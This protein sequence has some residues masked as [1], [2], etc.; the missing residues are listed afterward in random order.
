VEEAN[1]RMLTNLPGPMMVF[2]ARDRGPQKDKMEQNCL[3]PTILQL[4]VNSQVMLLRNQAG[5][6]GGLVN[7]SLGVLVR[8]DKKPADNENMTSTVGERTG[9]LNTPGEDLPVVKFTLESG[10][11][12]EMVVGREEWKIELPNGQLQG[13]RVQIPLSL[14]WSLSIHKSQGQTLPKVSVDLGRVFEKG[15]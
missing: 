13:A 6:A 12:R 4:K 10:E 7:G 5:G 14:A 15:T 11:T 8:F 9:S 1:N 2:H 3:A